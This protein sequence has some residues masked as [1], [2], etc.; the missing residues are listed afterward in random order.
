MVLTFLKK[1]WSLLLSYSSLVAV[2]ILGSSIQAACDGSLA[3]GLYFSW[4]FVVIL[5]TAFNVVR[6]AEALAG[7]FGEPY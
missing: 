1:E 2:L 4:M 3:I 6:H 7:I 5:I